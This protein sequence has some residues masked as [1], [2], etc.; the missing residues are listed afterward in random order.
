MSSRLA[1]Q[2][3]PIRILVLDDE[4]TN[5]RLLRRILE[6][7]GYGPIETL[8]SGCDIEKVV[9]EFKPHLMLLDLHMPAPDGF[10]VLQMLSGHIHGA[11]MLPVLVLT[12][13]ASPEA[14]RRALSLGARDFLAK[15]FDAQEALLRIRNLLETRF[16]YGRLAEQNAELESR[17]LERTS[18]LR[19]SQIEV[20]ERLARAG[21][22]RDDETGR[23]TQRVG[24]LSGRIAEALGLAQSTVDLICAAAPLHDL[25]KIGIPDAILLKPGPLTPEEMALMRL[26]TSI[27][28]KILSG[29]KSEVIQMA[30]R[31]ARSHHERWDGSGYPDCLSR[32]A[33]PLEARVVA[34]AD[35]VDALTHNRPYRPSWPLHEVLV[36]VQRTSGSH[37]DPD[38]V[39]A[40]MQKCKGKIVASSPHPWKALGAAQRAAQ[41][42]ASTTG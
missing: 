29:G 4:E 24:E 15:P 31:I 5:L 2:S 32:D 20:L 36:E 33:I 7:A 37:F 9:E 28:A 22:I 40:F 10:E 35:C 1:K 38:I 39:R 12:G 13:D 16:L 41:R 18:E 19:N 6:K 11:Q 14:K 21:E 8:V 30:E 23:H 34:L 17:V 27:G 42:L 26:H 25:G 3:G